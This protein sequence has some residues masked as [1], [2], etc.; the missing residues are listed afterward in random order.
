VV[1]LLPAL[2]DA[3]PTGRVQGIRARGGLEIDLAWENGRATAA[4]LKATVDGRYVLRAPEGQ[5]ID[6]PDTL[7]LKA[8][9]TRE[10]RFK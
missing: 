9:E 3:W 10:V 6:G 7:A 8:G 1:Q 5:P 4:V 2:P